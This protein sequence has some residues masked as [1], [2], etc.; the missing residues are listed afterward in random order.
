MELASR[1]DGS[2]TEKKMTIW[3]HLDELRSRLIRAIIAY[4]IG[5]SVAWAYREPMLTWLWKPF[6]DSW[7]A[8][9]IAGDPA[10]NF[11]APSDIFK[12]YFKLSMTGGLLF[13]APIIFYQLWAYIAPGLY[14]KEKKIVIP[15]VFFSTV[16]FVGGGLF[17]WRIAFPI[18]FKYFLELAGTDPNNILIIRPVV[19]MPEYLD[20][21]SQMLLAFGII[22]ELPLFILFLSIA[23][24]VNYLQLGSAAGSSS[25][26]SSSAPSSQPPDTTSQ[27]AMS[28]PLCLLYFVSI[29][30]AY[31]FGKR[32]SSRARSSGSADRAEAEKRQ[33]AA[34]RSIKKAEERA[35]ATPKRAKRKEL[36]PRVGLAAQD[37]HRSVELLGEHE[38]GE[39]VGKGHRRQAQPLVRPLDDLRRQSVGAADQ[40]D[41]P[42]LCPAPSAPRAT[43]RSFRW[44]WLCRKRRERRGGPMSAASS[45]ARPRA[46]APARRESRP[47]R[48]KNDDRCVAGIRRW[49]GAAPVL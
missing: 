3:E 39:T 28:V 11:A 18:T 27:I 31:L 29:G 49:P 2:M 15:F 30:L 8:A 25:S 22:F 42:T 17:G 36:D 1:T 21:V 4:V 35:S 48:S 37:G 20:F 5:V 46:P 7:R 10:L 13:A 26:R 34:R 40:E 32:P 9:G 47:P 19:M 45:R 23:G 24:I 38:A 12:A 33:K 44:S 6:A 16:L 43:V 41:D 14:K